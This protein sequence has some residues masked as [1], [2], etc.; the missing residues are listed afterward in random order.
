MPALVKV[1]YAVARTLDGTGSEELVVYRTSVSRMSGRGTKITTRRRARIASTTIS[2]VRVSDR[3]GMSPSTRDGAG[4]ETR[5]LSLPP[6]RQ[7][8]N[9]EIDLVPWPD[10]KLIGSRRRT[11]G[12]LFGT[13]NS[14]TPGS[15]FPLEAQGTRSCPKLS[16][17]SA[18]S[19]EP[20]SLRRYQST[21]SSTPTPFPE[22]VT[23]SAFR[24][25]A[26]AFAAS[27][28]SKSAAWGVWATHQTTR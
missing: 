23:M 4:G 13:A 21:T 6:L 17:H 3:V 26:A 11:I 7:R 27:W 22:I 12:Q 15:G 20:S 19:G 28:W 25:L 10:S 14:R 2:A 9:S 18:G 24:T 16:R 5:S 1:T 8:R